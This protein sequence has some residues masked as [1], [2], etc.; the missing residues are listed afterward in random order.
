MAKKIDEQI[1]NIQDTIKAEVIS[2]VEK[3]LEKARIRLSNEINKIIQE[4]MIHD[5]YNGYTPHV[6][7]RTFQLPF[8]VGPYVPLVESENGFSFVDISIDAEP[9]KYGYPQMDH[10]E[11]SV[12]VSW[13]LKNGTKK[14]KTYTYRLPFN[15]EREEQ[16]FE[17]FMAGVHPK[18]GRAG[19]HNIEKRTTKALNSFMDSKARKIIQEELDK[20]RF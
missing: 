17:N 7:K 16:I 15:L 8:T 3:A 1:N 4:Y 11:K 14:T 9:P 5:Y 20:I 19:T 2:K 13:K 18:V 10:S 6:Y 12:T